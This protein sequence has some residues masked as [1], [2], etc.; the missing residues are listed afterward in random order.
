MFFFALLV[1]DRANLR[2]YL[3]DQTD[4]S[5]R[6]S[7][8]FT[9]ETH[10]VLAEPTSLSPWLDRPRQART[11]RRKYRF[12]QVESLERQN[13]LA[14]VSWILA[15]NGDRN[16]AANWSTGKVPGAG[17]D[18]N[19]DGASGSYVIAYSSGTSVVNSIHEDG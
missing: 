1:I 16:T 12:D 17:D 13:L 3:T 6:P 2:I 18:V 8:S 15:G 10:H 14:E 19:L 9:L 5:M 7:P 4:A 11:S